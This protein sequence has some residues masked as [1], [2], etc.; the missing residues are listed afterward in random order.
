MPGPDLALALLALLFAAVFATSVFAYNKLVR[1]RQR[2]RNAFAQIDVQLT[3]RHNLV[4][5]LVSTVQGAM[6]HER[7]TLEAI[8]RTRAEAQQTLRLVP[9][10]LAHPEA[11]RELSR[12]ENALAALLMTLVA[13]IEAYPELKAMDNTLELMEE[14]RST[15]NRIAFARQ[16]YNDAVAGFNSLRDSFPTLLLAGMLG[17]SQEQFLELAPAS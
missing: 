6:K 9:Q 14:L 3:R 1:F 15:E 8:T 5:S 17:F 10:N 2:C 4:P 11:L 12:V 16:A 13:R 7:Q